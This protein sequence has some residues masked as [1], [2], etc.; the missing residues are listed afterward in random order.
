MSA[1]LESRVQGGGVP[2]DGIH[3]TGTTI[4]REDHDLLLTGFHKV[5]QRHPSV[6]DGGLSPEADQQRGV[7]DLRT[8]QC[9][10][11]PGFQRPDQKYQL[12]S[13]G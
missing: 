8:S 6:G 7:F 1:V 9:V 13:Q 2:R 3:I 10:Q 11:F 12:S 5:L 4:P